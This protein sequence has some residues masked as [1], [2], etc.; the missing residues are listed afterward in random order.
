VRTWAALRVMAP[1]GLPI[2]QES[3]EHP[4]AFACTCHSGVTLAAAHA[5]H[6]A[7]Y[8]AEGRLPRE[9][10]RFSAARFDVQSAA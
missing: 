5:L 9:L 2:Y 10:D 3:R 4:G 8:V 6:Y 1:D 7:R